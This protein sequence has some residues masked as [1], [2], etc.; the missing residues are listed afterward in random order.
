MMV[1]RSWTD[2]SGPRPGVERRPRG[3]HGAI[4]V[5]SP[6]Q[7]GPADRLP[8]QRVDHVH[9]TAVHRV[10]PLAAA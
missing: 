10:E 7:R 1:A 9:E 4:D 6:R 3:P 8:G 5:R 2:E